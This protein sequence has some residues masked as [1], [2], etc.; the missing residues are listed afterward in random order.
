VDDRRLFDWRNGQ[1]TKGDL[2]AHCG[3]LNDERFQKDYCFVATVLFLTASA[4]SRQFVTAWLETMETDVRLIDDSPSRAPNLPEFIE[5]RHDQAVF[6]CL[7][8]KFGVAAICGY[9]LQYP[10]ATP[11]HNDWDTIADYP[12]HARRDKRLSASGL[13]R[14]R[15][16]RAWARFHGTA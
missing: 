11:D 1:F 12:I 13:L 16:H 9:E 7:A 5:H 3:L 15:L 6:N 2:L 10:G 8:Y 4:R 14:A